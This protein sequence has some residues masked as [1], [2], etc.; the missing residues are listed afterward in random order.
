M[1]FLGNIWIAAYI[2]LSCEL[3]YDIGF[4]EEAQRSVRN[5]IQ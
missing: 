4:S 5:P 2:N 1:E 3:K